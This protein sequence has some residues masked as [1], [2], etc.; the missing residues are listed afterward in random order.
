MGARARVGSLPGG[1]GR[2]VGFG[3][4][5]ACLRKGQHFQGAVEGKAV[6]LSKLMIDLGF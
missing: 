1:V 6:P 2:P 3:V 5:G 4:K